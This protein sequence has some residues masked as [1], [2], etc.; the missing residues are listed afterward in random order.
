MLRNI[1]SIVAAILDVFRYGIG[2]KKFVEERMN[3]KDFVEREKAQIDI[4][5][6]NQVENVAKQ[7]E[8]TDA[9]ERRK[10]IEEMRKI[11]A[12]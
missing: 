8:S 1:L 11:L 4:D 3:E 10:A 9:E 6:Q 12:E 7:A 2:R 5:F